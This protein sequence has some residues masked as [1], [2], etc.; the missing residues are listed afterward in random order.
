MAPH[1]V[2]RITWLQLHNGLGALG[3]AGEVPLVLIQ[4]FLLVLGWGGSRLIHLTSDAETPPVPC[5]GRLLMLGM[6]ALKGRYSC[7][8]VQASK[9]LLPSNQD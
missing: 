8:R 4:L 6:R 7:K 3:Q 9:D 1:R 5:L 2:G